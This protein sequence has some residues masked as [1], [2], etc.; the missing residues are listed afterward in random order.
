MKTNP[1]RNA[2][3]KLQKSLELIKEAN[4]MIEKLRIEIEQKDQ[5]IR[6]LEGSY[7]DAGLELEKLKSHWAY[8]L[9]H[10]KW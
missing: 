5:R 2:Y 7:G 1:D 3:E 4:N 9:T 10:W 6:N 8:K